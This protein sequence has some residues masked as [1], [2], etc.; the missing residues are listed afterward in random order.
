MGRTL[1]R[2]STIL[3]NVDLR[4]SR[5]RSVDPHPGRVD[6]DNLAFAEPKKGLGRA[7][8]GKDLFKGRQVGLMRR[9]T[10]TTVRRDGRSQS[11]SQSFGRNDSQTRLG[12]LGR[13]TSGTSDSLKAR[14]DSH[15]KCNMPTRSKG[16]PDSGVLG[17]IT[18]SK[19]TI[20][21]DVDLCYTLQTPI[22]QF[23]LWTSN[24][25]I[26]S[27]YSYTGRTTEWRT[28]SR[29]SEFCH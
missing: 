19:C 17:R 2:A 23:N 6:K 3:T 25:V 27:S 20:K 16:M 28:N 5:S 13:K 22:R 15:G 21:W 7:P 14:R 18:I 11:Q 26:R 12:L 9:S 10:S 1:S 4:R 24:H 29:A 8:S